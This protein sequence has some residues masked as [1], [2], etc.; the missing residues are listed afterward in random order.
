[1][2]QYNATKVKVVA[3]FTRDRPPVVYRIKRY[4]IQCNIIGAGTSFILLMAGS[5]NISPLVD[6]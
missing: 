6:I 1:M 4:V 2:P 3:P 5:K